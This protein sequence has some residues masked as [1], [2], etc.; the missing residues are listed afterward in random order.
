MTVKLSL[1]LDALDAPD[2]P[3]CGTVLVVE[4]GSSRSLDI[5]L[6]YREYRGTAKRP[7]GA[8]VEVREQLHTGDL[9]TGETH[10]FC[11]ALPPDAYP[12]TSCAVTGTR[13]RW[14]VE[15]RSDQPGR[16]ASVTVALAEA[17]DH[18][19]TGRRS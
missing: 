7:T 5:R 2:A 16:D 13:M 10:A 14:E 8:G 9:R 6:L 15:A 4:G 12:D 18:A 3:V 19:T 11:L 17:K 1:E